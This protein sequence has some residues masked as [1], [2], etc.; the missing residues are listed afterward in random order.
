MWWRSPRLKEAL[1]SSHFW[2]ISAIL[3]FLTLVHYAE[4]TG[5]SGTTS[6]SIH[7]G[8]T[9]HAL[10]R[11]LF[12]LPVMY[13]GFVFGFI[14][15]IAVCFLTMLIMLPRAA[16]LS[17]ASPDALLETFAV[18]V[19]GI[20]A[21]Q[22]LGIRAKE[23]EEYRL[24]LEE[25]RGAHERL[26]RYVRIARSHEKRLSTLHAISAALTQSLELKET[27][28]VALNMV[29]DLLE[30]EI[31]LVFSMEEG[32]QEL[33]LA[34]YE[35]VSEKF[36]Q[37]VNRVKIG[38]GFYGRVAQTGEPIAVKDQSAY[39]LRVASPVVKQMKIQAQLIVPL[40]FKDRIV[41][42]LCVGNRHPREFINA[43]V[44][45][46]TAIG[47]QIGFAIENVR[48]YDNQRLAAQ[49][50][51]ASERRYR[52]LFENAVDAI[53]VHD[54]QGNIV[55]ANKAS[56][57]LTGYG[58]PELLRLNVK[59]FLSKESLEL[60]G[61]VRH[62]IFEGGP[63]EQPYRQRL[64]RRDGTDAILDLTTNLIRDGSRPIGFQCVARDVTK[65]QRLQDSLRLYLGQITK[66]Q[67]EERK[68]IAR[69]LHD[70]TAQILY[71]LSRQI[72][73]FIRSNESLPG[74]FGFFL[75]ELRSQIDA[76]SEG[77][78]SFSHD[79]R[80]PMI[81]DLGLLPSLEW[82]ARETQKRYQVQTELM[83][84]G[85]ERRFTTDVELIIFRIVQEAL[86][87]VG[88][89]AKASKAEITVRF[90]DG[91][92]RVSITDDG[93]GFQLPGQ[94][95]DLT[96]SGKLGLTGMEERVRLL[97]GTFLLQSKPGKGTTV[98]AELLV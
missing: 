97:G 98:E 65:E 16:F 47:N 83:V 56:E 42:A 30:A 12:L 81:D 26:Q 24:T 94:I 41:G 3:V 40:T 38:E 68:R 6:P 59:E 2:A 80:P 79:L 21:C 35:G 34:A 33:G 49:Q 58:V 1:R 76:A 78:R 39:D 14:P 19:V 90:E 7:F 27:L 57:E 9:R 50:A 28:T 37:E 73:N 85:T 17:P 87:N 88:R 32:S 23:R 11:I 92:T 48:L 13:S 46:L 5:I 62:K 45:L 8:L 67:E 52:E 54:L 22:W 70:D 77:V 53:W 72:D 69:E 93:K 89:H 86:R 74:Q 4:Q 95:A 25:L 84:V 44:D 91:K 20:I 64:I 51:F 18:T 61:Q 15:G 43:E 96:R 36:A 29:M 10:D 60:A 63:L 31:G 75:R 71:A 55:A 82:L 66:A